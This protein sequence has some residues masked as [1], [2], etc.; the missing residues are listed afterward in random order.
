MPIHYKEIERA[1]K[2]AKKWT[3]TASKAERLAFL[4][5]YKSAGTGFGSTT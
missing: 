5:K 2:E 1:L 4:Q 3:R